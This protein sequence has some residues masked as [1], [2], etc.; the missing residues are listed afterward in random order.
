MGSSTPASRAPHGMSLQLSGNHA[1]TCTSRP[2]RIAPHFAWCNHS[3][4]EKRRCNLLKNKASVRVPIFHNIAWC[5]RGAVRVA[6]EIA[7]EHLNSTRLAGDK[8]N[9][10][11]WKL[12]LLMPKLLISSCQIATAQQGAPS[13]MQAPAAHRIIQLEQGRVCAVCTWGSCAVVG[14]P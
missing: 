1:S 10:R 3:F 8:D 4:L 2:H 9:V 6:L 12:F 7:L 5:I 13:D 11:A 14:A